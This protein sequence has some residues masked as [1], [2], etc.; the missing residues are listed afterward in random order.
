MTDRRYLGLD[1]GGRRVGVAISDPGGVIA[2]PLETLIVGSVD[3]AVAK[4]RRL[5]A[6]QDAIVGV[7]VGLP[8]SMSGRASAATK[9]AEA[10]AERLRRVLSVPVYLED[11]RLSSRQAEFVL[12]EHGKKIKGHK[13]K[14]DRIA[15]ALIL[16]SFLDRMNQAGGMPAREE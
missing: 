2:Q 1:P 3:E 16:Q 8:V 10:F 15:A 13:D 5:I 12:H 9:E 4:V 7:V 14:L 11:E 6:E